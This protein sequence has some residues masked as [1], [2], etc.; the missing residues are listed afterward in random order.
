MRERIITKLREIEE[1]RSVKV[2]YACES[3]SR[4]WGFPSANSDYDVR[5]LYIHPINWY[6]S[7]VKRRD[8]IEEPI[9]DELDINGWDLRK[10]LGL[11]YK[12]NPPLLEWLGSP[13]VYI[14]ETSVVQSI[15]A[16]LP[17]FYSSTN[18]FSHYYHMAKANFREYLKGDI[19]RTK[20]YFYVLRPVL[21]MQWIER[22]KGIIPTDFNV[23][24]AEL[25][26]DPILLADIEALLRQKRAGAELQ[27][28]P[29]ID[30]I[31]SFIESEMER[32]SGFS[33]NKTERGSINT[34]DSM[35][36][37]SLSECWGLSIKETDLT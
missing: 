15:R 17:Q 11:L 26:S 4:A 21:A 13:I 2:I 34:L 5:F 3:G 24:V 18:C 9:V 29:R 20:K 35:F 30:S 6:L 8:V 19:V 22:E 36:R 31:S 12:S 7:V 33:F 25:I 27:T 10:A 23:L 1:K 32:F 28:G 37:Q 14:E 16:I